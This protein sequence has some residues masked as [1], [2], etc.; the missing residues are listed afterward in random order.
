MRLKPGLVLSVALAVTFGS[1]ANALIQSSQSANDALKEKNSNGHFLGDDGNW[2]RMP[3][4]EASVS[5]KAHA[6]CIDNL[7]L[8]T[9]FSS[10]ETEKV[11][12]LISDKQTGQS[13]I[14]NLGRN[15]SLNSRQA[16]RYCTEV[17]PSQTLQ[18]CFINIDKKTDL[19]F[20]SVHESCVAVNSA[21]NGQDCIVE[22]VK[23]GIG[24][25]AEIRKKCVG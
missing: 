9:G 1:N 4:T 7:N 2:Y 11:C 23:A 8:N 6:D 16:M 17:N 3:S 13:C 18:Q 15:S 10:G 14:I 5:E 12:L 19:P 21:V 22:N 25:V 24:S 20:D